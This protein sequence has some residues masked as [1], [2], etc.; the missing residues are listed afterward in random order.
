MSLVLVTGG[1]GFI[2]SNVVARLARDW[3]REVVVCDWLGQA[4]E[5]RWRNIAKHPIADIIPPESLFDWL[6]RRGEDLEL[7]VHL[8]AISS[9]TEPDVDRIVRNNFALSRDLFAWCAQH[10]RRLIYAS[11]AATYGDGDA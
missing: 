11:S 5:G 1:A 4:D 7:I 8:G 3:R 9:T 2:G 10:R 6:G